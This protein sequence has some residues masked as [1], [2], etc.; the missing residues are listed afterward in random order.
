FRK[1]VGQPPAEYLTNWRLTVAQ[2]RLRSGASVG[3]T[4]TALG[5]ATPAAFSR[6]FTQG[7]GSSPR[8]WLA[9]SEDLAPA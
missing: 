5:Y 4:A 6:A 2:E 7:I 8:A 3:R 9:A 1:L